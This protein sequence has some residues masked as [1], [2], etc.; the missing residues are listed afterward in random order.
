VNLITHLLLVPSQKWVELY[1]HPQY[2]F[3]AW[4]LVKHR[5]NFT[6]IAFKTPIERLMIVVLLYI[7]L[8][9]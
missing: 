6:F 9:N 8:F 2:V 1:L 4:W 3:M 5:D 7:S